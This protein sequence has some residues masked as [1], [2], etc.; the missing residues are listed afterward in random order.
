MWHKRQVCLINSESKILFGDFKAKVC[1]EDIF[2]P[3]V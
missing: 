3:T 1:K 2:K